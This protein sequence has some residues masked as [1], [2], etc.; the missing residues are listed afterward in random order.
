MWYY[1]HMANFMKVQGGIMKNHHNDN[2]LHEM[3]SDFFV[4]PLY[5]DMRTRFVVVGNGAVL[6]LD[7]GEFNAL[8]LLAQNEGEMIGIDALQEAIFAGGGIQDQSDAIAKTKEALDVL[9]RKIDDVEGNFVRI[10]RL[11]DS[12]MLKKRWSR[13]DFADK[14][15]VAPEHTH[16]PAE[17]AVLRRRAPLRRI[18]YAAMG[19]AAAVVLTATVMLT[20]LDRTPQ[21]FFDLE[22]GPVPM[23]PAPPDYPLDDYDDEDYE[24]DGGVTD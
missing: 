12:Y 21:D 18:A 19:T 11:N 20:I 1:L 4:G 6:P 24:L 16:K 8:V 13:G 5:F 2:R 15:D 14:R 10:E 22:D 9:A 17:T 23:V 7:D 3:Q